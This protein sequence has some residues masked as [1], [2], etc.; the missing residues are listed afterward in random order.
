MANIKFYEQNMVNSDTTFS[1]TSALTASAK[2]IYDENDGTK[3]TSIASS[4]TVSEVWDM[5][6]G[7]SYSLTAIHLSNHN[8][9]DFSIQYWSD[10]A[11][12][13]FSTAINSTTNSSTYGYFENF[14]NVTTQKIR[15]TGNKTIVADEQKSVGGF[16]AMNLIGE[17]D[18]NSRNLK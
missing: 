6:F 18:H 10:T 15:L 5:D 3:L 1:L 16:R 11:F 2:Y 9:K 17:M 13:D 4:D 8:L 7:A 14:T 12:V